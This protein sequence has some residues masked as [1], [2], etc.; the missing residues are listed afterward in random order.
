MKEYIRGDKEAVKLLKLMKGR[1]KK[2]ADKL[3]K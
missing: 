2:L 1:T 3:L